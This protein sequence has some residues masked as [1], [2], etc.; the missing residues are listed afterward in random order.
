LAAGYL[1]VNENLLLIAFRPPLA[2]EMNR[3]EFLR[4]SFSHHIE[5]IAK[6]T[7]LDA[8]LFY[9][10]ECAVNFWN[11]YTL[12]E[13]L[14]TDLYNK[15]GTMP[16]NFTQTIPDKAQALKAVLAFKYNTFL[17]VLVFS[18]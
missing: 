8:R 10:H 4:I 14:R 3:E 12:R 6:T 7:L 9:I 17:T 1:Q 13:Y 5:I 18:F 15:R 2:G 11:K 16:N